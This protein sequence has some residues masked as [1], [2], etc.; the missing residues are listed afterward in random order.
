[1]FQHFSENM[2]TFLDQPVTKNK[3]LGDVKL[4]EAKVNYIFFAR[5]NYWKGARCILMKQNPES[6][7][8]YLIKESRAAT[9]YIILQTRQQSQQHKA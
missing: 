1:M 8:E 4:T 5:K 2:S 9:L 3:I 7:F 6:R